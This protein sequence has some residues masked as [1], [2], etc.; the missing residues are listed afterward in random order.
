MAMARV[1]IVEDDPTNAELASIICKSAKHV[2]TVVENGIEALM[3]LDAVPFELVITDVI[4]PRMDG[5]T[6]TGLIRSSGAP[7]ANVPIIG[8]TAK[9]DR[10]SHTAMH[11]AGMSDVITKP[12]RAHDLKAMVARWLESGAH[13]VAIFRAVEGMPSDRLDA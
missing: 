2:V 11:E 6:M 8:M 7:Y 1:L 10:T 5:I 9:A 4:M 12:F 3:L 13:D